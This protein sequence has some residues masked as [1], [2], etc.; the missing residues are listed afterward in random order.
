MWKNIFIWN[1][2][3]IAHKHHIHLFICNVSIL[4]MVWWGSGLFGSEIIIRYC[5][6]K[7]H[8]IC[9]YFVRTRKFRKIFVFC[10]PFFRVYIFFQ[11][12]LSNIVKAVL[13]LGR[14]VDLKTIKKSPQRSLLLDINTISKFSFW[15]E[16][17]FSSKCNHMLKSKPFKFSCVKFKEREIKSFVNALKKSIRKIIMTMV[18]EC[19]PIKILQFCTGIFTICRGRNTLSESRQTK[20]ARK[21]FKS[22]HHIIIPKNN[23]LTKLIIELDTRCV[24]N[25]CLCQHIYRTIG[26]LGE[27]I[28][29]KRYFN[30]L[31]NAPNINEKQSIKNYGWI[32]HLT[33]TTFPTHWWFRWYILHEGIH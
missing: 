4:F 32:F 10:I 27:Q 31:L 9:T 18:H 7:V 33:E 2:Y 3:W 13:F 14:V 15:Y 17:R 25:L 29:L 11:I 8:S 26:Y 30:P 16:K 23:Q 24:G 22:K 12:W 28:K 19:I 21:P 5:I 6:V 1:R 20:R